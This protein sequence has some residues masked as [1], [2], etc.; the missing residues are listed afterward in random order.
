VAIDTGS[1]SVQVG[2]S[3]TDYTSLNACFERWRQA[4]NEIRRDIAAENGQGRR[5]DRNWTTIRERLT[6]YL[7]SEGVSRPGMFN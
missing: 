5:T 1:P 7:K 3:I 2:L 4:S 6:D